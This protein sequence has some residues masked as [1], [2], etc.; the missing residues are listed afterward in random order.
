[1][2]AM[3]EGAKIVRCELGARVVLRLDC[4]KFTTP[5][6]NQ[7]SAFDVSAVPIATARAGRH[8]D[9]W[10]GWLLGNVGRKL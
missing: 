2:A 5:A 9:G 10:K 4:T 1:M 8:P 3:V 7:L 6:G